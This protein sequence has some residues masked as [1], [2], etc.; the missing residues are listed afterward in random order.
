MV[1]QMLEEKPRT[2]EHNTLNF[3]REVL[4]SVRQMHKPY[5]EPVMILNR[6]NMRFSWNIPEGMFFYIQ[7]KI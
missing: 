1:L 3:L 6:N 5:R 2:I 7:W 4:W